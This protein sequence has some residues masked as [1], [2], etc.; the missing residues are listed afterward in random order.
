[1]CQASAHHQAEFTCL[2]L[3]MSLRDYIYILSHGL[4][5]S[6]P[7]FVL[8]PGSLDS[9]LWFS[10]ISLC[11]SWD[12]RPVSLD[13]AEL[14]FGSDISVLLRDG[15]LCFLHGMGKFYWKSSDI[16]TK[17]L[18][19]LCFVLKL[20]FLKFRGWGEPYRFQTNPQYFHNSIVYTFSPQRHVTHCECERCHI[21]SLS[22][23]AVTLWGRTSHLKRQ[24]S[25]SRARP[26]RLLIGAEDR[27][28]CLH[29]PLFVLNSIGFPKAH[30]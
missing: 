6:L 26:S 30:W 25:D 14:G 1:M 21:L 29:C 19:Q 9:S 7:G 8:C 10:C 18:Q 15:M 24:Q 27:G 2:Y 28:Q 20:N 5:K 3:P 11:H 23:H 4:V 16:L 13:P 22:V 12:S 17:V